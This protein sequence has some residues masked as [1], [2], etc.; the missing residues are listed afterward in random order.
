MNYF[1]IISGIS[2]S[3]DITNNGLKGS[4]IQFFL[5]K[6]TEKILFKFVKNQADY[7]PL[8]LTHPPTPWPVHCKNWRCIKLSTESRLLRL[9]LLGI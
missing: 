8:K 7:D 6:S 3:T 9:N 4:V 2:C 1:Y 5:R